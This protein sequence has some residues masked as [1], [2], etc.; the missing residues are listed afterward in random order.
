M[1]HLFHP[2]GSQPSV[3]PH[4]GEA[5]SLLDK[6]AQAEGAIG[7]DADV[8]Q[9]VFQAFAQGDGSISRRYGGTGLGL[10]ITRR[11]VELMG[12]EVK[13]ESTLGKG[14]R[15]YFEIPLPPAEKQLESLKARLAERRIELEL[16]D[17]A[18]EHIIRVGYDPAFGARP[19]KRAIQKELETPLARKLVGGEVKDGQKVI[20][21]VRG[22]EM[23]LNVESKD[24]VSAS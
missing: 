14:S 10:A 6:G 5:R 9:R 12:G 15:F 3:P 17:A 23:I 4:Q 20:A 1:E 19:L 16:T 24:A 21:D 13:L 7:M 11:Q 18:R 22:G 8:S 2:R